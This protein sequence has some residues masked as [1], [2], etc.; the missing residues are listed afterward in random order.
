MQTIRLDILLWF[1]IG[2]FGFSLGWLFS[3]Y[4]AD[5]VY[6][7]GQ[8]VVCKY[9]ATDYQATLGEMQSRLMQC[10]STAPELPPIAVEKEK[11]GR[12]S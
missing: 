4:V 12:R 10:L 2:S 7:V 11:K 1:F 3:V 8:S 5:R 6:P 9:L